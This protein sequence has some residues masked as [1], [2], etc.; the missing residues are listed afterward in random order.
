MEA[1]GF[2]SLV[3]EGERLHPLT[4]LL[5]PEGFDEAA[6]RSALLVKHRIEVGAGLGPLAGKI[7]RIGLMAGNAQESSVDRLVEAL[8]S[9]LS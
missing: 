5:L 7:W 3:P 9:E 6:R 1:F 2:Q 8:K 4:T